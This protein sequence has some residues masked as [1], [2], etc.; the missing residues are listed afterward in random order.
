MTFTLHPYSV[1]DT[2]CL[3]FFKIEALTLLTLIDEPRLLQQPLHDDGCLCPGNV[4]FRGKPIAGSA[5]D[6]TGVD[7]CGHAAPRPI[8][9]LVFVEK[10]LECFFQRNAACV[11][12]AAPLI[13]SPWLS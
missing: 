11:R 3:D 7:A 6:D 4:F 9:D 12:Q 10:L 5:C 13:P 2:A 8:G 1:L